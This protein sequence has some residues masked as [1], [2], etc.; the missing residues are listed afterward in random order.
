[1]SIPTL[2]GLQTTLSGLLANQEAIDVTGQNITNVDTEGYSR[3][4]AVLETNAPLRIASLSPDGEGGQLGTGVSVTAFTRIRNEYLDAQY[5]TQ[6]AALGA[7][8]TQTN[9]LSQ[10]QSAFDEPSSSSIAGQLSAF[11]SAWSGLS[12][13]PTS[14]AAKVAV[15]SAG[16]QLAAT[17]K[18]VDGQLAVDRVPGGATVRTR[19][20]EPTVN[21]RATRP[22]SPSSTNRS[23]SPY[24][25]SR[26]RMNWKTAATSCSTRSPNSARSPSPRKAMGPTRSSS[27]MPPNRSSK[28]R[29]S[30]GRRRI[31]TATG[32]KLGALLESASAEGPIAGTAKRA[33]RRRGDARR[34]G[35]SLHTS[36][37]FFT[38][39]TAAT[40]TVAVTPAEVQTAGA[41]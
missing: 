4:V 30:T 17:L 39:N 35:Q 26:S 3:Q 27:A 16:K 10:A 1:M 12:N 8:T 18:E 2:Q 34:I 38:G 33:E 41:G 7:S 11:W 29:R 15:V 25:Q 6:N 14:E 24:R 36:T 31:T 37:P 20:P 13:D 5:R 9:E 23:S 22:R 40:L 19:S 21:F 32:G 28:A